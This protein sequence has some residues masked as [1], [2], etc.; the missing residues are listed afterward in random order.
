MFILLLPFLGIFFLEKTLAIKFTS[1]VAALNE[2][3]T[4]EDLRLKLASDEVILDSSGYDMSN[5]ETLDANMFQTFNP[6]QLD[7]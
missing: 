4:V 7:Q 6:S 3:L 2:Q 1:I 5:W